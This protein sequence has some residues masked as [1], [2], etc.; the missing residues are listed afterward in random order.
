MIITGS[1]KNNQ[2]NKINQIGGD[3][4]QDETNSVIA[5]QK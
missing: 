5:N 2:I 3:Q 4:L 1:E